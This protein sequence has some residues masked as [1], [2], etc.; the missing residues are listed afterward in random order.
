ME[1]QLR[2]LSTCHKNN[3][4]R[5]AQPNLR[6]N[7][8][9]SIGP[10]QLE[11][12]LS[13]EVEAKLRTTLEAVGHELKMG[14]VGNIQN[15][16]LKR[17]GGE[18]WVID[19]SKRSEKKINN[20]N[21]DI[22]D[23]WR[24]LIENRCRDA[25]DNDSDKSWVA[26][27]S[28][29]DSLSL[30]KASLVSY[31]LSDLSDEDKVSQCSDKS[32]SS[33][34]PGSQSDILHIRT[35]ELA[36]TDTRCSS[37][38]GDSKLQDISAV[39]RST[40]TTLATKQ[41]SLNTSCDKATV[42]RTCLQNGS[43]RDLYDIYKPT[44]SQVSAGYRDGSYNVWR[45]PASAFDRRV[46]DLTLQQNTKK[47]QHKQP[48]VSITPPIPTHRFV[49]SF[50][51]ANRSPFFSTLEIAIGLRLLNEVLFTNAKYYP[52]I[53]LPQNVT[54]TDIKNNEP[55]V[56]EVTEDGL[57]GHGTTINE[58]IQNIGNP[59]E[60]DK[61]SKELLG[62]LKDSSSLTEEEK[63]KIHQLYSLIQCIRGSA[64]CLNQDVIEEDEFKK[65]LEQLKE[66]LKNVQ[67][68][69]VLDPQSQK[70]LRELSEAIKCAQ[71]L[72]DPQ[73]TDLADKP[74]KL[75]GAVGSILHFLEEP[76]PS[77]LITA[78]V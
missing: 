77:N 63:R 22:K 3:Y 70:I 49:K 48:I 32:V 4:I 21:N 15:F 72:I 39:V 68:F 54:E 20:L 60:R 36:R 73:S 16:K 75:K 30:S 51:N 65:I 62:V 71:K 19:K 53:A 6:I 58:A 46:N 10:G 45:I 7:I 41:N 40:P 28:D 61:A 11:S 66:G 9:S 34:D 69:S 13:P 44:R 17:K 18:Y 25:S 42:N 35:I 56:V 47:R 8:K 52:A 33:T 12:H 64:E 50:N 37:G 27:S 59:R 38:A 31:D 2:R 1:I 55:R 24:L 29:T 23:L 5:H 14:S 78:G 26:I 43:Q 76:A 57:D 74:S 67:A